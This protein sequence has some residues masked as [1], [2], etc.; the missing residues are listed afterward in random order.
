MIRPGAKSAGFTLIE[1]IATIVILGIALVGIARMVSLGISDSADI[2][3]QTRAV[4]LAEA[5][6]DEI[7]GRRFDENA[8]VSGLNP[9]FGLP[10]DM[11]TPTRPCSATL[12]P[13]GGGENSRDKYDDVDDYNNLNEGDGTGTPIRDAKGDTR[14]DYAN[15]HVTVSVR[16]AGDD[17]VLARTATHAKL[18]TVTVTTRDQAD[19]WR[20]S[21]YKGNY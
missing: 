13:N 18:I 4:A 19:G 1:M 2:M 5:Y 11:P 21:V 15:F 6:L 7:M 12:G 16:Y 14:P 10:G 17:A 8:D 3:V 20:F 9:C